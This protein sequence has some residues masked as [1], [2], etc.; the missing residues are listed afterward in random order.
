MDNDELNEYAIRG[1]D[2]DWSA[3]LTRAD[4]VVKGESILS[5]K[6]WVFVLLLFQCFLFSVLWRNER[7]WRYLR[8][9]RDRR[10]K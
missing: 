8:R 6:K 5:V 10:R 1:T 9:R 3:A 2:D 4:L 7:K